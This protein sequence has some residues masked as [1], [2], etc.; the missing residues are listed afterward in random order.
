M[1]KKSTHELNYRETLIS[2]ALCGEKMPKPSEASLAFIRNFARNFRVH[3]C[4]NG[5]VCEF[6]LN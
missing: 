5:A 2:K 3:K 4:D 6:V 1:D